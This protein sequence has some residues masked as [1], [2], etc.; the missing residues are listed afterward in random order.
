MKGVED[1]LPLTVNITSGNPLIWNK[2]VKLFSPIL[3]LSHT[4]RK[5][6]SFP[7]PEIQQ[8]INPNYLLNYFPLQYTTK[9][10]DYIHLWSHDFLTYPLRDN[11]I[12]PDSIFNPLLSHFP[13]VLCFR[14]FA[15]MPRWSLIWVVRAIMFA[16]IGRPLTQCPQCSLI[17]LMPGDMLSVFFLSLYLALSGLTP[18]GHSTAGRWPEIS[19]L[20]YISLCLHIENQVFW[21]KKK[22]N[23][24]H[25]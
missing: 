14:T 13:S 9:S 15:P 21:K 17:L 12:R 4:C 25:S 5:A 20:L 11:R 6:Y 8:S 18:W 7:L 10:L 3:T 23:R 19:I 24:V 1:V 22:D 16:T 2:P